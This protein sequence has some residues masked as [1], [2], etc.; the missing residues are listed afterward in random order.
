MT[1]GILNGLEYLHSKNIV[2][3]DIKPA[4][5]LLQGDTPRLADFG[6][7][8]VIHT[9]TLTSVVG[10]E[11]Y[12]S[13]ESFEGVRSAQTDVWSVG[14]LL[15]KLLTGNLPFPPRQPL[16]AMY[17]ILHKP[18]ETLPDEIPPLLKEIVFKALEK[19]LE[20]GADPPRRY[21]TAAA[22]RDDLK[23]FLET[24]Q[25]S[26]VPVDE[27]NVMP[28]PAPRAEEI[29][30]RIRIPV[31]AASS[32]NGFRRLLGNKPVIMLVGISPVLS[33][34]LIIS[35]VFYLFIKTNG[36]ITITQSNKNSAAT[37][38]STNKSMSV[39]NRKVSGPSALD[40]F[41]QGVK[42]YDRKN[43]DWAIE[44]FTK[45]IEIN[46]D[47]HSFYNNR[48]LALYGKRRF[49]EAIADFD[50][51]LELNPGD[52]AVYNNRGV[53][54]EESG[55]TERAIADYRKALELNPKDEKARRNLNNILK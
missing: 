7:S 49:P 15:Y 32:R 24:L 52:S 33:F 17:A 50:K 21:Q 38:N 20:L 53:A 37:S 10:T 26:V 31:S 34:A 18:P 5:I 19:D 51:A 3:R 25:P 40:Y 14:V 16:E 43:Y 4:N 6:I 1:V 8:R 54:Y 28:P 48:G 29:N 35:L 12:M 39:S 9:S 27:I 36:T 47:D 44:A 2:H 11:S 45:A 55:D 30:T 42:F 23:I 22:M 46:P 13:P 41:K